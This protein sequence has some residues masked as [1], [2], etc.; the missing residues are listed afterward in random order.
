M[1]K[2]TRS[3]RGALE[4]AMDEQQELIQPFLCSCWRADM[5]IQIR[6]LNNSGIAV[7][8]FSAEIKDVPKLN[9]ALFREKMRLRPS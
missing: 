8:L 5:K 6:V 9:Q 1:A 4:A 3:P 2:R 7:G